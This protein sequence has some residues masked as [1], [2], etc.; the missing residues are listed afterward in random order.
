MRIVQ[1]LGSARKGGAE[2]FFIRLAEALHRRGVEQ[3]VIVRRGHWAQA[4]LRELNVPTK[5][6]FFAGKL[7]LLTRRIFRQT[8]TATNADIVVTWMRRATA[9]CPSGPWVHVGRLGGYYD[10]K[11]YVRCD[12]LIANTPGI[13][14][15]IMKSGWLET[16]LSVIANF[17]P[18]ITAAPVSRM[19]HMTPEGAPLLV[20]LGRME[21]TKG[22]DLA[23][24]VL[25]EVPQAYLWLI[26]SG[27]Y[28]ADV[29]KLAS[30][31]GVAERVRFLGWHDDVH[32]FLAAADF[33]LC[34]SRAEAFGNI[35]L[36]AW[37]H[38]MPIVAARSPGPEHLIE[39]GRTGLLVANDD[40]TAMAA[41]LNEL[42][43]NP[44]L[45]GKIAAAGHEHFKVTYSEDA[46]VTMYMEM[47][48]RLVAEKALRSRQTTRMATI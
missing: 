19:S 43:A 44:D 48:E 40:P 21:H 41:A 11:D 27:A 45:A 25:A 9:A 20:W 32:P 17:V 47:F 7:D 1:A 10:L 5:G 23:V 8:L 4:Q 22:P 31:L 42:L 38:G 39:H 26:G 30:N 37:A 33:F 18:Q 34:T 2:R 29:R 15:H 28:E 13:A 24:R 16:R 35:L 3:T 14:E 6:V 12:H 36:E 46:I